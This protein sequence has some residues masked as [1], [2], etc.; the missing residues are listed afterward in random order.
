MDVANQYWTTSIGVSGTNWTEIL[1]RIQENTFEIVSCKMVA[2]CIGLIKSD[3]YG[4]HFA[5]DN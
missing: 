1:I 5:G 2:I 4:H 3:T